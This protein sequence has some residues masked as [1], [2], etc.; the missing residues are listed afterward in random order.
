MNQALLT[1]ESSRF[2]ISTHSYFLRM[3]CVRERKHSGSHSI[4]EA[5]VYCHGPMIVLN[6]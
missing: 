3:D 5:L 2:L 1:E 6:S 4:E